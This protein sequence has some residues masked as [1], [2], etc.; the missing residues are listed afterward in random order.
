MKD[1]RPLTAKGASPCA[2][3]NYSD[4]L[5]WRVSIAVRRECMSIENIWHFTRN[6]RECEEHSFRLRSWLFR[7]NGITL[8]KNGRGISKTCFCVE[9]I[10]YSHT[11]IYFRVTMPEILVRAALSKVCFM[12]FP[13]KTTRY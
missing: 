8:K 2:L 13:Y 6:R 11:I 4:F 10:S 5:V 12:V 1:D 3:G 7:K 9:W